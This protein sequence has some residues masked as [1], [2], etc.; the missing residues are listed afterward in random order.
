[1]LYYTLMGLKLVSYIPS[2]VGVLLVGLIVL[3]SNPKNTKNKL[4][5]LVNLLTAFWLTFLLLTDISTDTIVALW[6][7][8]LALF[9]G[10]L[11]FLSFFLFALSF[12]H[13]SRFSRNILFIF[14]LPILAT[15][16]VSF[17]STVVKS[18]TINDY[19][20]QPEKT[21]PLF[22]VTDIVSFFY[23]L[24]GMA[25]LVSKYKNSSFQEK[26]QIKLVLYGLTLAV[27]M[28]IFTGIVLTYL[29]I[30]SEYVSFGGLSLLIF[31]LAVAYSIIRNRLFDIR[32]VALRSLGYIL[33]ITVVGILYGFLAFNLLTELLSQDTN[34]SMTLRI[35]Y[36]L[37]AVVLVFTFQP[38]KRFFD[39]LTNKLFYQDAY[40]SQDLIDELNKSL[41][42]TLDMAT[43][44]RSSMAVIDHYIKPD[45][46][47][48]ALKATAYRPQL[49]A[50][51]QH[52]ISL[53]ESVLTD[54]ATADSTVKVILTDLLEESD[55]D[56]RAKLRA[57]DI[58]VLV[59]LTG[60]AGSEVIGAIALG[61]KRSGNPYTSQ[62]IKVL[63]IAANT[64]A[65]AIQNA[66]SFEEIQQFNLTLTQ[67]VDDATHK[68]KRANARLVAL[69]QN[70]DDFISMVSHQLRTP[71]TSIKGYASMLLDGDGGMPL[72]KSEQRFVQQILFSSQQMVAMIGDLLNL[73]RLNSGHFD[74]QRTPTDIVALVRDQIHQLKHIADQK[75]ITIDFDYDKGMPLVTIDKDKMQ[76]VVMNFI[77]NAVHYTPPK[78][79]VVVNL[80]LSKRSL[81]LKVSDSGIGVPKSDQSK[82]FSRYFRANNAKKYRPSG[83]GIGLYMAK[84]VIISHGGA[85]IFRANPK[86]GST[87]GFSLPLS[88]VITKPNKDKIDKK[89]SKTKEVELATAD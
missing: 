70:K 76:Q 69:D 2:I 47:S 11:V 38:I 58:A 82:L 32:L 29:R 42:S 73:S 51:T 39:K 13:A 15:A 89:S 43:I 19:S 16:F 72:N 40:D 27:V 61:A 35:I 7:L 62:D 22:A 79:E 20:V 24:S 77:D 48:F 78:G 87:F 65:I 46:I 45:F 54:P 57:K 60:T 12:P 23:L 33:A 86:G 21:G 37:L 36:T 41:V 53:T 83:T 4:F 5:A 8:R 80:S 28:N 66:L 64:L 88:Q 75:E 84:K 14:I 10:T 68:L 85:V 34:V 74:M 17:T 3:L 26:Q 63:E 30:D 25:L 49:I 18:V 52:K 81:D 1:M 9:F 50:G 71:L 31:S 56:L 44:Q 67:R 55:K 6:L 59:R